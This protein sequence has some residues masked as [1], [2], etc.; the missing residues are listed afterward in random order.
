MSKWVYDGW[1][2]PAVKA[3]PPNERYLKI[4][5]SPEVNGYDKATVLFSHIPPGSGTGKHTH[6]TDEIMYFVGR[7][8]A[9]VDGETTQLETDSVLVAPAG[10]E[11][12]CR[13]ISETETLKVF[14][15]YVPP[16]PAIGMVA[17]VTRKSKDYV[18]DQG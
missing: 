1:K 10:V 12:E 11:H 16:L 8:E 18:R 6:P 5:A 3:D 15:V 17:E 9:F 13:N 2:Y 7:G 14:C 4:I